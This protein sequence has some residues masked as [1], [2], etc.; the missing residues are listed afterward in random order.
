[1]EVYETRR[2]A[3]GIEKYTSEM[4]RSNLL[5]VDY[6]RSSTEHTLPFRV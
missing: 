1:M 6:H 5:G 2:R 3:G 4:N